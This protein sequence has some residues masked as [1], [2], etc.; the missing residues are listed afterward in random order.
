[1]RTRVARR[2]VSAVVPRLA[3]GAVLGVLLGGVTACGDDVGDDASARDAPSGSYAPA[4]TPYEGSLAGSGGGR[5]GVAGDVVDCATAAAGFDHGPGPLAEAATADSVGAAVE[6]AYSEGLQ[7]DAPRVDLA[8]AREEGDRRLLTFEVGGRVLMALVV[9]DGP[10]SEGAGGP[11]WY[12]QSWARCD[13]AEFPADVAEG[14]GVLVWAGADGTPVP[15]SRVYSHPGPEHCGWQPMTFL[16]LDD[17][18]RTEA[19]YVREPIPELEPYVAVPYRARTALPADA[20]DTGWQRAGD[21]LWLS[22]DRDVAY[23][24]AGDRVEAWPR[25][26]T[27]CE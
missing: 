5:Y 10:A 18:R 23:V 7:L 4:A 2:A 16:A 19:S 11:G 21:H 17:G 6:T 1:M 15:T 12:V 22:A 25:F 20:V 24:G 9:R 26:E 3:L 27:G 13:Y 8:L 14:M